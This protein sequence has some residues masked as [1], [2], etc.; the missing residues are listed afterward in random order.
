VS[1]YA[2]T[3][4]TKAGCRNKTSEETIQNIIFEH[5]AALKEFTDN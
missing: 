3:E 1:Y 5:P 4:N 2:K